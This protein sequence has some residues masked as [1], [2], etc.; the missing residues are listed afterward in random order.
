M[1]K[2][3]SSNPES[4]R[5]STTK[6]D[7]CKRR[8]EADRRSYIV[9]QGSKVVYE[10]RELLEATAFQFGR[11]SGRIYAMM[12]SEYEPSPDCWMNPPEEGGRP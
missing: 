12:I 11:Q 7:R 4:R 2:Q 5:R 8:E 6:C 1:K 3:T 9:V 10:T